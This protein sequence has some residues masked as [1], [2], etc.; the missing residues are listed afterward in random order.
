MT[1][2]Q[3]RRGGLIP[4]RPTAL[5]KINRE[6]SD[7][8]LLVTA[9]K[10]G[11]VGMGIALGL[12]LV[13][14]TVAAAVVCMNPDPAILIPPAALLCLMPSMFAGGFA[15]AKRVKEAPLL[16]GILSG[17]MITIIT[18]IAGAIMRGLSGNSLEN[19]LNKLLLSN[20]EA[21]EALTDI[22]GNLDE[23]EGKVNF[24]GD[25]DPVLNNE[26]PEVK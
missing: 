26:N 18:I 1:Q 2:N 5:S 17:G 19:E 3:K 6:E 13:L 14:I 7:S 22:L 24:H 12:G 25:E 8:P 15:A 9:L 23:P 16:C 21:S 11:L 4:S 20:D 10:G